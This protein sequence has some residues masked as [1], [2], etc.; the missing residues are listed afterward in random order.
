MALA[1]ASLSTEIDSMSLGLIVSSGLAIPLPPSTAMGTPSITISGSFEAL[2]EAAPR[3]RM[4][5]LD[6]GPPSPGMICT[7]GTLPLSMSC[8]ETTAPRLNSSALI[9]TTEPVM[10]FFLTVP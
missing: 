3:T 6:P 1:E 8:V 7:P 10:S 9:A 2:S 5:A 4:V